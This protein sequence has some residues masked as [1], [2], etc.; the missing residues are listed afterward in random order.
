LGIAGVRKP[1]KTRAAGKDTTP[2]PAELAREECVVGSVGPWRATC[3]FATRGR[4]QNG[5]RYR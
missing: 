2:P 1:T 3:S 5:L 4:T